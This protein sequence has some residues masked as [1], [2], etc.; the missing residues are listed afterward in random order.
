MIQYYSIILIIVF[1]LK[2]G[3]ALPPHVI[4]IEQEANQVFERRRYNQAILLYN[5]AIAMVPDSPILY[6]NRA[7]AYIERNWCVFCVT[8][9]T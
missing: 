6:G 4:A 3:R 5:Q 9:L 1:R 8:S 7:A 2:H